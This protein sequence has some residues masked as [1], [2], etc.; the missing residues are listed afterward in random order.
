MKPG[1]YTLGSPL[2]LLDSNQN[3]TKGAILADDIVVVTAMYG[4]TLTAPSTVDISS[5]T[6]SSTMNVSVSCSDG[7]P[8]SNE[9]SDV[10]LSFQASGVSIADFKWNS[11]QNLPVAGTNGKAFILGNWGKIPSADCKIGDVRWDGGN[12]QFIGTIKPEQNDFF[13][14]Q[15]IGFR[16]CSTDEIIPG[17]YQAQATLSIVQR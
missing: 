15:T 4:C 6:S 9:K 2:Y 13:A 3:D 11:P 7:S 5:I 8:N 1:R 10:Y 17:S 14:V 16:L 12:E